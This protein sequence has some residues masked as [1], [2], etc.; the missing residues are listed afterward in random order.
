MGP[1]ENETRQPR[2]GDNIY[3]L[4]SSESILV[5]TITSV[6]QPNGTGDAKTVALALAKRPGPILKAIKDQGLDPPR[7][8]EDVEGTD[9]EED[10]DARSIARGIAS[11]KGGSGMM[12]PPPLDPLY[13]LEIVVG[14]TYTV[15]RLLSVPSRKYSK[16]SDVA[17]LLDYEQRGEVVG[18]QNEAPAYFKSLEEEGVQ[19]ADAKVAGNSPIMVEDTQLP[20]QDEEKA[21]GNADEGINELLAKAEEEAARAAAVA[22][23]ASAE[24]KRKE[25]KMQILKAKA[26]AA[27]AARQKKKES[28]AAA[29]AEAVAVE[30][31]RK[32]E[33]MK[34][35]K[36]KAEAAMAA[37]RKKKDSSS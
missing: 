16:K 31:G 6:A 36:A 27:M 20:L 1:T 32:E 30:A 13:N 2:P 24:A 9:D 35:L 21:N 33:K 7:W 29:A 10:P 15:G 11:E 4:G 34:L 14:G 8:W 3:V 28:G 22:E 5:G 25:E 19:S 23:A 26:D 18:E 12:Q 17:T 37:R